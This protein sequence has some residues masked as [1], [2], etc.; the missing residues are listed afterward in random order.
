MRA[1]VLA[2]VLAVP[3]FAQDLN[4]ALAPYAGLL[5]DWVGTAETLTPSG[6]MTVA[7]TETVRTELQ[8]NLIVV[9]GRGRSLGPDGEPSDEV[10]FNAFGIFSV[11]AATGTVYFDAFTMEGRHVRV[12]PTP[13]EGGFDWSMRPG[14]RTVIAYEV[15]FD[16]AGRWVETG[17]VSLDDGETWRPFF[18]MTLDRVAE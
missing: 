17:E 11:D 16:E 12:A 6:P 3:A 8:G 14:G 15:R 1:L 9:E 5:G 4:P 18:E 7:Q 13:V 2:V 10:G